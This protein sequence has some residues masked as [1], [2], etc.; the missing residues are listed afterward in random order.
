MPDTARP[1]NGHPPGSSQGTP[2]SPWFWC[3]LSSNDTSTA[4]PHIGTAHRLPDPHL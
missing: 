3:H 2:D 4:I 1:V